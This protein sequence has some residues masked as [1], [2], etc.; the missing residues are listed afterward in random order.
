MRTF[1]SLRIK[2]LRISRKKLPLPH[3]VGAG[4]M[5]DIFRALGAESFR[6]RDSRDGQFLEAEGAAAD[7]AVEVHVAVAVLLFFG[8]VADFVAEAV[9]VGDG[10]QQMTLAERGQG[11]GNDG[12]VH[13]LQGCLDL[14]H[15]ERPPRCQQG[16]QDEDAVG[17]RL[18]A[19]LLHQFDGIFCVCVHTSQR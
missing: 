11:S 16:F 19:V 2:Y 14:R 10:M 3:A 13:G 4:A 9:A 8:A 15:G 12:L 18:D 6:A 5:E 7:V 17:G 1:D